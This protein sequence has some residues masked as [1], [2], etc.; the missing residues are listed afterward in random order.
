ML[1]VSFFNFIYM[2]EDRFHRRKEEFLQDRES[3]LSRIRAIA[4]EVTHEFKILEALSVGGNQ[5]AAD[6]SSGHTNFDF[7][8][9]ISER[10]T[11]S[12]AAYLFVVDTNLTIKALLSELE[13]Y[14]LVV[15][16]YEPSLDI[17]IKANS[18][19]LSQ[20]SAEKDEKGSVK[21]PF[22]KLRNDSDFYLN[23]SEF[24]ELSE[25]MLK[26]YVEMEY[27][28]YLS[29]KKDRE[30]NRIPKP[31]TSV[32]YSPFDYYYAYLEK[33]TYLRKMGILDGRINRF[34]DEHNQSYNTLGLFESQKMIDDYFL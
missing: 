8:K 27:D 34:N 26:E 18:T 19:Y 23:Y 7:N 24:K 13:E 6:L 12:E 4:E 32:M 5:K 15:N 1:F 22:S 2:C 31:K 9:K 14:E 20:A 11:E 16:N 21:N 25:S 29:M 3:F 28:L 30:I 33:Q 10:R 17:K